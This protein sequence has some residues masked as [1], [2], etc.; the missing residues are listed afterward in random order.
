MHPC[1][2]APSNT[3]TTNHHHRPTPVITPTRSTRSMPRACSEC[4][5]E[6]DNKQLHD[7]HWKKCV[8]T[9]TFVAYNKQK[10]TVTRHAN[11]TF[12]CYCSHLRCPKEHGFT[13]LYAL[14]RHLKVSKTT[15]LGPEKKAS[16]SSPSSGLPP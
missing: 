9:S 12:V 8:K 3:L 4:G 15:W 13:T 11:G 14:Q 7:S 1:E 5:A 10:I 16:T 2:S 6:F